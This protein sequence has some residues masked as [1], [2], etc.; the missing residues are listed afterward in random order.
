MNF[1][2]TYLKKMHKIKQFNKYYFCFFTRNGGFS[3]NEFSTL[4]C[5]YKSGDLDKNVEENRKIASNHFMQNKIIIPNQNHSN[6]VLE[7]DYKNNLSLNADAVITGRDDILLGILTADCAPIIILGE[8]KFGII[9]AG[10]KGLLNG[11]IENTINKL[12]S[13]G[14]K[15]EK[16]NVFVG[17]HLK[18]YSFEVKKDFI[19]IL[20]KK[21][22]HERFINNV[23]ERFYFNFSK[24]IEEKLK[25][26]NIINLNISSEN[27]FTNPKKFFSHRFSC[28]NKIKKCGR[29]ISL[30]GIMIK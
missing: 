9:H 10:W 4:N 7:V 28:V 5:A 20:K 25:K 26:H 27:T 30:V 1:I 8:N 6:K 18:E 15:I 23:N 22:D 19:E 11:I 12:I 24:L 3:D 21:V 17:P 14:E 29:Q 16:L 13:C 2:P